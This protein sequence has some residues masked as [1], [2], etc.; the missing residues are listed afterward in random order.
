MP[1]EHTCGECANYDP[2]LGPGE[3]ETKRGWCIPRSV[4]PA[5]EGPGQVF[6]PGVKRAKKG[7]LAKPYIVK[8]YDLLPGCDLSKKTDLD[9]YVEKKKSQKVTDDKG[10]RILF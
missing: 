10:R 9:P 7:E 5:V 4:Y 8:K 2:I 6:P 1:T 3:K